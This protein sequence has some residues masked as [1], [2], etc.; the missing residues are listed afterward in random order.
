MKHTKPLAVAD[1]KLFD[2]IIRKPKETMS[3]TL[4]LHA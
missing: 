1:I 4:V 3:F 2:I